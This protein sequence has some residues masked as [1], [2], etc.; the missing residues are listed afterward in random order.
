M[1]RP[2]SATTQPLPAIFLSLAVASAM[3]YLALALPDSL[4]LAKN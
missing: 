2:I 3:K 1:L 4:Q